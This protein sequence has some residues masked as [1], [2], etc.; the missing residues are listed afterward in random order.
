MTIATF[1]LPVDIPW[2]RIAFSEDMMDPV[3]CDRKLP[4]RWQSSLAVFEYQPPPD[5]QREDG[6]IVSYLKVACT[7]TGYQAKGREIQMREWIGRSG[8]GKS[9]MTNRLLDLAGSYFPCNGA[10]LEVVVAP[11]EDDTRFNLE[12][13][14]YFADFD[15]K[16]REMYE[17]VTDTG[18][19]MS[20][21]LEDVNVRR[22]QTTLQSHE[23]RDTT[24]LSA[25]LSAEYMGVKASGTATNEARTTDLNQQGTENVRTSDAA[26]EARETFS[27]TTQLSQMYHQLDS[28]H[29]GTNRAAFFILPRPHVV[30]S[31]MTFVPGPREIE[32][33]QEFMLVV[34]RPKEMEEFCVE[35]YLETAHLTGVPKLNWDETD[36]LLSLKISTPDHSMHSDS[37][38][39]PGRDGYVVD[40]DKG[41]PP[42]GMH[43]DTGGY[44]V[45][46]VNENQTPRGESSDTSN[47]TF[48]V[49]TEQ[50]MVSG[51]VMGWGRPVGPGELEVSAKVFLK[52]KVPEIDGYGPGLMITGRAVCSC[53]QGF[54][55]RVNERPS[56]VYEKALSAT[57]NSAGSK[58][59]SMNIRDANR[60]GAQMKRE[61]LQSLSSADRYPRGTVDLLDSQL[62]AD[63]MG[64]HLQYADR[65]MN[66][67]LVDFP[68]IDRNLAGRV[69]A[70]TP[71]ITRSELLAMPLPDQ[72]A[73]FALTFAEA[74]QLR[75]D[76][77][78]ISVP[79][80][81]RPAPERE[82]TRVPLLSGLRSYEAMSALATCG[83]RYGPATV[84]DSPLPAN[85]V[86]GQEPEAQTEVDTETEV[87]VD[88]ASGL[89]VRLP[90]IRGLR[91]SEA[92]CILR[93]AGLRSEPSVQGKPTPDAEVVEQNPP[94]G[95]LIT[96]ESPTSIILNRRRPHPSR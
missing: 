55:S 85:T 69:A 62:F 82:K 45:N 25:S 17:V 90:D 36:A 23:V 70:V 20:R 93:G 49:G 3:A 65:G 30:Q 68:G 84:V 8:L 59:S 21:S 74:V 13:Y 78:G 5:L 73:R 1:S 33:V 64:V 60:L 10:I 54:G 89:S 87:A 27:H 29:L 7:I 79:E 37:Q 81:P 57:E 9:D 38:I 34:V 88:L 12:S 44:V 16:K 75:R 41:V 31:P 47:Y 61:L 22:G 18:E 92:S 19:T 96:P 67:R 2:R 48:V 15:P 77:A 94:A 72:V 66:P 80:G 24:T 11:H 6:S 76:L 32:G 50:V 43:G 39:T 52:K 95:T 86:I 42:T 26:R 4:P 71:K 46:F 63:M 58:E 51:W 56:I 28:Y 53:K 40:R 35:A 91:L 83:L 14:P